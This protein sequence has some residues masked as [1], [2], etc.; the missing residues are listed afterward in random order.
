MKKLLLILA[1]VCSV[2]VT[3]AK[4]FSKQVDFSDSTSYQLF[5]YKGRVPA[6]AQ[7][8]GI[9]LMNGGY[10][11]NHNNSVKINSVI[12]GSHKKETISFNMYITP[13]GDGAGVALLNKEYISEDSLSYIAEHWE[14][15]DFK[16]AFG[17]GFDIYNPQTSAWFDKYG[18]FYGRPQR[19]ISLHWD[20][21]EVFKVMS[22]VEFRSDM[23][24]DII[25]NI[26]INLDYVT[27]GAEASVSID[28]TLVI[29]NFF[30]AEMMPYDKVPVMG[31][32]TS[33]FTTTV[34]V[35]SL[36][37]SGTGEPVKQKLKQSFV[38]AKDLEFHAKNREEFYEVEFP[39]A[40]KKTGR[41]IMTLDLG[42]L[43]GG[44]S[45]WDV[46]AGIYIVDADSTEYEICRFIT[47]Y[48]RGYIWKVDVTDFLPLFS[49][50]KFIK[51][52]CSTWE[53]V[54]EDPA[55]QKGW[56]VNAKLDYYEGP[57]DFRPIDV[58]NLWNGNEEYGNPE[59]P[60]SDFFDKREITVPRK[61]DRVKI[62]FVVT[63]HGMSPNSDN[64]AE[65]MP[66]DRTF[67][68]NGTEF[69]NTLWKTDN[70]L[71]PCRPQGGTWKFDRAGW[72]PGDVVKAWEIDIT[73]F[74]SKD[75]KLNLEYIPMEYINK[76]RNKDTYPPHHK[77]ATQ[78]IY[79]KNR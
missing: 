75:R 68:V 66:A 65:F 40:G 70:Y 38:L 21:R 77:I 7:G 33:D 39:K 61:T 58:V 29:K 35:D 76:N 59:K 74:V 26:K 36:T 52:Q 2:S 57:S 69:K 10:A 73:E 34:Y 19:E 3:I 41:V 62:R 5:K 30:I 32:T 79:Y 42:G 64:A 18:N 78:L 16:K 24:Q 23:M 22:P 13:G 72:A 11:S 20:G 63:G 45:G 67:I 9:M 49:Q 31:V 48:H 15:P 28:D 46:G 14:S 54:T 47:P 6:Q 51:V 27:G 25:H 1:I 4:D 12:E 37:F 17:V 60:L 53:T 71:N 56:K 55:K 43:A 44:P 50:K 8:S